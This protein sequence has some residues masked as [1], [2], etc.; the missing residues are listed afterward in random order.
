[1]KARIVVLAAVATAAVSLLAAGTAGAAPP[2]KFWVCV[3]SG[4]ITVLG[5]SSSQPGNWNAAH[6]SGGTLSFWNQDTPDGPGPQ[7]DQGS[8]GPKGPAGASGATGATGTTG[9]TGNTGNQGNQGPQGPQ[10]P[11]GPLGQIYQ[12]VGSNSGNNVITG[13]VVTETV[14]CPDAGEMVLSG[15][16]FVSGGGRPAL[17]ASIADD[18]NTWRGRGVQ[19][20]GN[21]MLTVDVRI[22][23][24][25]V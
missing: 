12:A 3:K 21:A 1:M 14:D 18:S 6:C 19:L 23:C 25:Q 10:G 9:N 22:N 2:I 16:T 7:G 11:T 20:L 17:Q 8:Q 5:I 4:K 13:G 24:V 15:G